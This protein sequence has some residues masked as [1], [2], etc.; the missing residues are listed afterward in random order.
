MWNAVVSVL[1]VLRCWSQLP[2]LHLVHLAGV[3]E[4]SPI[5]WHGLKR[6]DVYYTVQKSG[7]RL[8]F[9]P[10]L[11]ARRLFDSTD[12]FSRLWPYIEYWMFWR[13]I[14]LRVSSLSRWISHEMPQQQLWPG[15]IAHMPWKRPPL[16]IFVSYLWWDWMHSSWAWCQW[17]LY[18]SKK[19]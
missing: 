1:K 13:N 6:Y 12:C 15:A 11:F 10:D 9:P 8:F 2:F 3:K 19:P 16:V 17:G 4:T 5:N 14:P 7:Y 18:G